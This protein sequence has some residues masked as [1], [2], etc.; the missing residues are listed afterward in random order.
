MARKTIIENIGR[1]AVYLSQSF[2]LWIYKLKYKRSPEY[3]ELNALIN[4]LRIAERFTDA[5]WT[6]FRELAENEKQIYERQPTVTI[7]RTT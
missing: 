7:Y 6:R 1:R 2:F 3:K 5:E 4:R